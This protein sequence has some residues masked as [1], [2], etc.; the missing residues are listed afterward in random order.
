MADITGNLIKNVDNRFRKWNGIVFIS[1]VIEKLFNLGVAR[2]NMVNIFKTSNR[3]KSMI[4]LV[5]LTDTI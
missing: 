1:V 5:L 4:S 2:R 3:G